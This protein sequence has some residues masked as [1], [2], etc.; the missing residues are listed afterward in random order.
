MLHIV[1]KS[2]TDGSAFDSAL[3]L[4]LIHI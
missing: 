3:R 4:S 2:P 1:N